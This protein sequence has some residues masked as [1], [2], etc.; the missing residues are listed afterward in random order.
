MFFVKNN[1]IRRR[2]IYRNIYIILLEGFKTTSTKFLYK[3]W[4]KEFLF[5]DQQL[6]YI[7]CFTLFRY[8]CLGFSRDH[9]RVIFNII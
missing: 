6:L 5:I 4:R 1:L 9:F 7:P 3:S 2:R 8:R